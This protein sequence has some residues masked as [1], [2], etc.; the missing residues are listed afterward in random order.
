MPKE[1]TFTTKHYPTNDLYELDLEEHMNQMAT[2]GWEL[3]STEQLIGERGSTTPQIIL[4]WSK[5]QIQ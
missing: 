4:F 3:V 5:G 1:Y 2:A